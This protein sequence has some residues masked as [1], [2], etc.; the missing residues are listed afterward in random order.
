MNAIV[1][2]RLF[3][4][5]GFDFSRLRR[6]KF[7]VLIKK[8]RAVLNFFAENVVIRS[9]RSEKVSNPSRNNIIIFASQF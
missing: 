4:L 3:D 1:M 7:A 9:R 2:H 5:I 8:T 6:W